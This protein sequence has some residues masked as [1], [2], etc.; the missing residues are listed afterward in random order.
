MCTALGRYDLNLVNRESRE[1]DAQMLTCAAWLV[2][3]EWERALPRNLLILAVLGSAPE[4]QD[5]TG[6]VCSGRGNGL[7]V[8]F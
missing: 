7:A 2:F 8:K 5:S 3:D 4:G 6:G 1:Y